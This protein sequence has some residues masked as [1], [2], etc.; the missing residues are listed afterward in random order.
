MVINMRHHVD[1]AT[2]VQVL[3]EVFK[4]NSGSKMPQLRE[5]LN[6]LE[7]ALPSLKKGDVLDFTY[8]PG[9]GRMTRCHSQ[10]L[11]IPGEDFAHALFSIW[12]GNKPVSDR[13][14]HEL[15]GQVGKG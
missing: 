6:L 2:F 10:E 8:L 3:E 9:S 4:R 15:L 1:R 13:L 12:L 14:K 5:R 11:I 7:H